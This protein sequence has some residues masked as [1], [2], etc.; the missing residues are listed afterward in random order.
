M[1]KKWALFFSGRGTNLEAILKKYST[2]WKSPPILVTNNPKSLGIEIGKKFNLEIHILEKPINYLNLHEILKNQ[3]VD[4]IFLL[5]FLKIIPASFLSEWHNRIFNLH[6]SLLPLY[7]G[8]K[9]IDRAYEDKSA[10]GVTIHKVTE[11]IDQG[12]ILLQKQVFKMNGFDHL[13]LEEVKSMVHSI[14]HQLVCDFVS[15]AEIDS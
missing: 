3:N 6:P 9:S 14:E 5:G 8:L 2:S 7:P 12:E 4:R 1:N 13:S 10:I 15:L 11:G